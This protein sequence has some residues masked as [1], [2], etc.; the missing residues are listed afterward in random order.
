MNF[1]G[2]EFT[3]ELEFFLFDFGLANVERISQEG[4][5]IDN[6]K[7]ELHLAFADAGE[8]EKVVDQARFQ[9]NVPANELKRLMHHPGSIV[10]T[11]EHKDC[12]Q[13]RSEGSA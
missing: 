7:A 9:L 5:G 8:I 11:F 10:L 4:V 2:G 6:F 12:R 13:D 1:G 3:S